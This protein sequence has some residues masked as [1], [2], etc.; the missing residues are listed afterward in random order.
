[1]PG[2]SGR[3]RPTAAV[4]AGLA[5]HTWTFDELFETVLA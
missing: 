3:R 4:M 5:D 2:K 1:L